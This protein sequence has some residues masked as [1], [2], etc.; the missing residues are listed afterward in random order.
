VIYLVGAAAPLLLALE[1]LL[2]SR[3]YRGAP[4]K[5]RRYDIAMVGLLTA[6]AVVALL[7]APLVI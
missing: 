5:E 2:L 1:L 6:A 7:A 4:P 3:L